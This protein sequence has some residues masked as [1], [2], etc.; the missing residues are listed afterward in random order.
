MLNLGQETEYVE[1]KKTTSELKEGMES[2]GSILN[3]HGAGVLYFGVQKNGDVTGQQV[4]EKTLRDISQAVSTSIEPRIYPT[5]ERLVSD[6][7]KAYVRVQF[8]GN[9][10]PYACKGV[11]RTRASDEDVVMT[12]RELE[13]FII[14]R[15]YRKHPWDRR[16]SERPISDVD[17]SVLRK[18]VERG[19]A[20]NRI[21]FEY[22]TP[23]EVLSSLHLLEDGKLLNAA[24]ALFCPS[25]SVQLKMGGF[26]NH[27]RIE[28]LDMQ[29]EAGTV[30]ELIDK[31]VYYI[32]NNIRRHLVVTDKP[33]RDEIPEIPLDAV[34]EAVTNGY[35][36]RIW[37]LPGYLQV[38]IY[39][40]AVDIISPGW[41]I[42]GQEPDEHLDGRSSSANTRNELIA[43]TLFRSG[44]I[45]SSGM[46]MRKIKRLCDEAGVKVTYERI[47]YGTKVTFHRN[48]PYIGESA[49]NPPKNGDA[50]RQPADN[51]PTNGDAR[52]QPAD[53]G[54][55]T[56]DIRIP[57][58]E[59]IV[60]NDRRVC[61]YLAGH[62]SS[63]A[64]EVA[65]SLGIAPRTVRDVMKRLIGRGLVVSFGASRNR[66]YR[67]EGESD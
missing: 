59:G 4:A 38:D 32:A 62:G 17:E 33:T 21:A 55:E 3:K 25:T 35:A 23:E 10:P 36:H 44:D 41:F 2:I 47:P 14:E 13:A 45:E 30:F 39:H 50:R 1:H 43:Q 7:G 24:D 37:Y 27:D 60:G 40:D 5:I 65:E 56:A 48:D 26:V 58:W 52:R 34:R 11:Y 20:R 18:F 66:T 67:L 49:D 12:G 57:N 29:Q 42:N 46:G 53:N 16:I 64:T 54:L 51:P 22:T 31:A 61:D 63:T 9:D 8:E 15:S 28:A 6:D 19:R